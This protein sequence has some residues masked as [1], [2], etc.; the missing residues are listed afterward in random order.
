MLSIITAE[1]RLGQAQSPHTYLDNGSSKKKH[2]YTFH[3][4]YVYSMYIC[5]I[6]KCEK[7]NKSACVYTLYIVQN[8]CICWC[9]IKASR[10]ATN[11]DCLMRCTLVFFYRRINS[12]HFCDVFHKTCHFFTQSHPAPLYVHTYITHMFVYLITVQCVIRHHAHAHSYY[13]CVGVIYIHVVHPLLRSVFG[14]TPTSHTN[15]AG[16]ICRWKPTIYA[17]INQQ[18]W[19]LE[20]NI[21]IQFVVYYMF[22][23]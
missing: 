14:Y 6:Y 15:I 22:C 10:N 23:C 9:C 5:G 8:M 3:Y 7:C 18:L 4:T 21:I 19:L 16:K 17:N 11:I 1:S 13:V 20:R 12:H 2:I